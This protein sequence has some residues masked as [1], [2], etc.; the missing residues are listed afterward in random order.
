VNRITANAVVG[1]ELLVVLPLQSA[2]ARQAAMSGMVIRRGKFQFISAPFA[3]AE[4]SAKQNFRV[5]YNL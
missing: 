3:K 1:P 5:H 4:L 2:R